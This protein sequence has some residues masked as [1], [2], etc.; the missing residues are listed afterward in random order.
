MGRSKANWSLT[1]A[2]RKRLKE[3]TQT[4]LTDPSQAGKNAVRA[5]LLDSHICRDE[6]YS[7]GPA[8]RIPRQGV[9]LGQSPEANSPQGR[10]LREPRVPRWASPIA[11]GATSALRTQY[12]KLTKGFTR[13]PAAAVAPGGRR[14]RLAPLVRGSPC[15]PCPG[16]RCRGPA[17]RY[18]GSPRAS[19]RPR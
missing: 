6:Q 13:S 4:F 15:S 18:R 10:L 5:E 2:E 16:A 1:K 19:P 14:A 7:R 17:S 3:G 11:L 8:S 12:Q 9:A